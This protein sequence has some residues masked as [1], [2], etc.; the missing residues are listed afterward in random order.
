MVNIGG[1][2]FMGYNFMNDLQKDIHTLVGYR[3][4]EPIGAGY[5]KRLL[6]DP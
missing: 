4:W 6:I 2:N 3:R 1:Y 5:R